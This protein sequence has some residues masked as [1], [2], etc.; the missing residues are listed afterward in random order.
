M[1]LITSKPSIPVLQSDTFEI[2]RQKIN[3]L[4]ADI[5]TKLDM[6]PASWIGYTYIK[7]VQLNYR[8]AGDNRVT[9]WWDRVVLPHHLLRGQNATYKL[10]YDT[11]IPGY[12]HSSYPYGEPTVGL[13][14]QDRAPAQI[15]QLTYSR[16]GS[17]NNNDFYL[18]NNSGGN[19][20]VIQFAMTDGRIATHTYTHKSVGNDFQNLTSV[21][22]V[23]SAPAAA[24]GKRALFVVAYSGGGVFGS[25]RPDVT[26][27]LFEDN[28][29]VTYS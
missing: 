2:Q 21:A 5:N 15:L 11:T 18:G 8:I 19:T 4:A 6:A 27:M 1:P 9:V 20:C 14:Y 16:D 22:L 12:Y 26:Q 7:S 28:F 13:L 23:I 25:A 3:N 24:L 29:T 17:D 10:T